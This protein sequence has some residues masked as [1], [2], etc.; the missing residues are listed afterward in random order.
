MCTLQTNRWFQDMNWTDSGSWFNIF[1]SIRVS[2]SF[3]SREIWKLFFYVQ[4]HYFKQILF[5]PVG[6]H[7]LLCSSTC[8]FQIF[9]SLAPPECSMFF[10]FTPFNSLPSPHLLPPLPLPP[11]ALG[12]TPAIFLPSSRGNPLGQRYAS[13]NTHTPDRP[14][15]NFGD[16][17][18]V[19]RRSWST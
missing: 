13:S 4:W 16:S 1:S 6:L 9:L 2:N 17:N 12:K 11:S 15:H 7:I 14:F 19:A 10:F 3:N 8:L 5:L 18:S